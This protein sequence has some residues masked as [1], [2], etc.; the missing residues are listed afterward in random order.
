MVVWRK[1]QLSYRSIFS[2]TPPSLHH[3]WSQRFLAERTK[4]QTVQHLHC[5]GSGSHRRVLFKRLE[6]SSRSHTNSFATADFGSHCYAAKTY[7]A[8]PV[9]RNASLRSVFR[10]SLNI[11]TAALYKLHLI[12]VR[13]KLRCLVWLAMV[14]N[15]K[16]YPSIN[17]ASLILRSLFA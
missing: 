12:V 9:S 15:K 11:F 2:E 5:P 1:H 10:T 6:E 16:N 3:F 4:H 8:H 7:L 14:F 17:I 13:L